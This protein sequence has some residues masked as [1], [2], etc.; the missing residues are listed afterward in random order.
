MQQP[1]PTAEQN[2]QHFP[3]PQE[4]SYSFSSTMDPGS[5]SKMTPPNFSQRNQSFSGYQQPP[6]QQQQYPQSPHKAYN[7]QTHTHQGGLQ[8]PYIA[9]RQNMP[10][11]YINQNPYSQQNRSVSSLTQDRTG[12]PV[13]HLPYPVNNDDPGYQLQP[14][15]IQ[16]HHPPQQQQQQQQPPLQTRR[17]LRKAPSSNL[18]PIQT[19]Q[20]YYSPDARRIVSTPT[21]QQNFPTPIPPEARTKSLTSASLKTRNNHC[22]LCNHISNKSLNCQV[23]TATLVIPPAVPFI[24]HFP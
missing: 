19:D 10:P 14:L 12:A 9:Q 17:Q 6:P 22:N 7:Q 3:P 13:Q 15:A 11:G 18:P 4:R 21:H 1:Y 24:I 20:V 2:N 8:Q 16:S 23:K 5:P